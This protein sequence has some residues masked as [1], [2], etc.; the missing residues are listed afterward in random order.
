MCRPSES[1][2]CVQTRRVCVRIVTAQR[3][4]QHVAFAAMA[5][6]SQSHASAPAPAHWPS[7]QPTPTATHDPYSYSQHHAT[8]SAVHG[9][10]A[11]PATHAQPTPQ[12]AYAA[13][14]A[15]QPAMAADDDLAFIL[16][17]L[18]VR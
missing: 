11:Q 12:P 3:T 13:Y 18:D 8:V 14:S 1:N 6:Q 15:P 17:Q 4:A 7:L 5:A 16:S 10:Y 2:S 9:A